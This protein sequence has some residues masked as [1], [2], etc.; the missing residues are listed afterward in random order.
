MARAKILCPNCGRVLGDTEQNMAATLNCKHCGQQR[1]RVI[2]AS[3]I[4]KPK[5]NDENGI[6]N[7]QGTHGLVVT[8]KGK[9]TND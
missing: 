3:T 1:V 8:E 9:L 4:A 6:V 7:T 5:R 2:F